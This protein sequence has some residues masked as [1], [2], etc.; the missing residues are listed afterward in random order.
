MERALSDRIALEDLVTAY[1]VAID[2]DQIGGLAGPAVKDAVFDHTSGGGSR[3]RVAVAQAWPTEAPAAVPARAHLIVNRRF[4]IHDDTATAEAHF[5][6]RCRCGCAC[7]GATCGIR[8]AATTASR[9][10]GRSTAGASQ[11]SSC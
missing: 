8:A 7:R 1:A 3:G 6:N 5:F 11:S 2:T 9:S 10:A 4:K